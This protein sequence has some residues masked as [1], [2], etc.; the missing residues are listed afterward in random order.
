MGLKTNDFCHPERSRGT[1][2]ASRR[3]TSDASPGRHSFA[4]LCGLCVIPYKKERR[5]STL[6][7]SKLKTRNSKLPSYA[8]LLKNNACRA[9]GWVFASR[10]ASCFS[11]SGVK[12]FASWTFSSSCA[13]ESHPTMTVLTGCVIT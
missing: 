13:I 4:D 6:R 7:L 5:G 8:H 9:I 1:P 11:F 12:S 2:I 3:E 10:A